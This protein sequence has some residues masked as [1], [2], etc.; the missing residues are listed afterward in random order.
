M[1]VNALSAT[2]LLAISTAMLLRHR[3]VWRESDPYE[4]SEREREYRSRQHRRRMQTSSMIGVIGLLVLA[5]NWLPGGVVL[6]TTYWSVVLVLVSWIV[7]L[8][9]AD[10][11]STRLFFHQVRQD[12]LA[13]QVKLQAEVDRLRNHDGNGRNGS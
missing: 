8:A 5:G 2:F 12:Q 10:L 1:S 13:E 11:I 6:S 4:L 7:W 9:V 3:S